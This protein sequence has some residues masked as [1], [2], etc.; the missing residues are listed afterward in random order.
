MDVPTNATIPST[1]TIQ[2]RCSAISIPAPDIV[3]YREEII[4]T[5]ME[6]VEI[7][8]YEL[9][10]STILSLLEVRNAI[11]EDTGLYRCRAINNAGYIDAPFY[12]TINSEFKFMSLM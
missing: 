6:R 5:S 10:S 4:L 11:S 9:S 8:R 12:L 1:Q 3:W 2:F 7:T